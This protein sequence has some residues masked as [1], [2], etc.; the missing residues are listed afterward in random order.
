MKSVIQR[1]EVR[2][3]LIE[4]A[5]LCV[6]KRSHK[7]AVTEALSGSLQSVDG[8]ALVVLLDSFLQRPGA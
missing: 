4:V 8:R 5:E 1:E 3:S 7:E 6:Q 2:D